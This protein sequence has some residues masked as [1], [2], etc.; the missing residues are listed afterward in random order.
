LRDPELDCLLA[1]FVA[2][3]DEA[4]AALDGCPRDFERPSSRTGSG[5]DDD[6]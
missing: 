3:L 5:I 4:R 6:V 1:H 2:Q